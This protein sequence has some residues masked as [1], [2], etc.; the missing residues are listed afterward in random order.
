MA[1]TG[2]RRSDAE[3]AVDVDGGAREAAMRRQRVGRTNAAAD[4]AGR[5]AG[6]GAGAD[7]ER[8]DDLQGHYA[9]DDGH[10]ETAAP[11]VMRPDPPRADPEPDG[12]VV[13]T[14]AWLW[15]RLAAL[16][17]RRL[18]TAKGE[19]FEVVAVERGAEVAVVPLDGGQRWIVGAAELEAAYGLIRDGMPAD[20]LAPIRLRAAG[21]AARH[22]EVVAGL[23]RALDPAG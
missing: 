19:P 5:W 1:G 16:A 20:R 6:A 7:G 9:P 22:P 18:A 11:E 13:P 10:G 14:T 17:G 15:D 23:L 21:V 2:G 12:A 8:L 4:A 3:E